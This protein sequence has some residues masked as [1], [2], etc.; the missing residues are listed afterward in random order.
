[1][2]LSQLAGQIYEKSVDYGAGVAGGPM[3]LLLPM[4]ALRRLADATRSFFRADGNYAANTQPRYDYCCIIVTE[5]DV[6]QL[7]K[8]L[9]SI[10][11]KLLHSLLSLTGVAAFGR[12]VYHADYQELVKF[13]PL[14]F[15]REKFLKPLSM[16]KLRITPI[17]KH[18]QLLHRFP[19][20]VNGRWP[21]ETH[22][23]DECLPQAGRCHSIVFPGRW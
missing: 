4:S 12:D 23:A 3:K 9:H 8:P 21:D 18:H 16:C 11:P 20:T 6:L 5:N 17:H 14:E 13:L 10:L 1:M 7:R 15:A 22:L 2:R 19:F